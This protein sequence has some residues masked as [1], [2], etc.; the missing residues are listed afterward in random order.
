MRPFNTEREIESKKVLKAKWGKLLSCTMKIFRRGWIVSWKK[1]NMIG[2]T[3]RG[4]KG[5]AAKGQRDTAKS[6]K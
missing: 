3:V 6:L 2:G 5:V 4:M 1:E